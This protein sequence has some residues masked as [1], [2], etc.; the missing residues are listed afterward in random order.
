MNKSWPHC[1]SRKICT[2][3]FWPA[4]PRIRTSTPQCRLGLEIVRHYE[5]NVR[6]SL[7]LAIPK[8]IAFTPREEAIEVRGVDLDVRVGGSERDPLSEL[9]FGA[10]RAAYLH[11]VNLAAGGVPLPV[12]AVSPAWFARQVLLRSH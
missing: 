7:G 8:V 6:S 10:V 1:K 11:R 9:G 12:A 3:E 4:E 5:S 2:A